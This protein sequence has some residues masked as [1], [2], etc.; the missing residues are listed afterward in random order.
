MTFLF[1]LH[2]LCACVGAL[3]GEG[4]LEA[5]ADVV[6]VDLGIGDAAFHGGH[7]GHQAFEAFGVGAA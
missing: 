5:L 6:D 3:S 7:G 2:W 4:E 1:F